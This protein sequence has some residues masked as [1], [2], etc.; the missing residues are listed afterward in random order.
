MK[1][2]KYFNQFLNERQLSRAVVDP[3]VVKPGMIATDYGDQKWTVIKVV[4]VKEWES[5]KKYDESGAMAEGMS[6]KETHGIDDS[7]WLI[8]VNIKRTVKDDENA[9][10]TYGPDGACVWSNDLPKS[11]YKSRIPFGS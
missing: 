11:K 9:V 5:V 4:P 2:T 10:F 8:A 6:D 3:S 1:N 7:T